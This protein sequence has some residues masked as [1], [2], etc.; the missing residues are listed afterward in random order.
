MK[1]KE[2]YPC[3]KQLTYIQIDFLAATLDNNL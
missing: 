3:K 1:K 2:A